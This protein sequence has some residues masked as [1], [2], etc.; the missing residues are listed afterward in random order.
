MKTLEI[1][2]EEM[3][4]ISQYLD[5]VALNVEIIDELE[6]IRKPTMNLGRRKVYIGNICLKIFLSKMVQNKEML[7]IIAF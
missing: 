4:F 2:R 7:I 5:Y 6:R 1:T 3:H